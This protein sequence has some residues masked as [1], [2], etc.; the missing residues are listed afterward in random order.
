MTEELKSSKKAPIPASQAKIPS[1]GMPPRNPPQ[2]NP[3]FNNF[4]SKGK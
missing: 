4:G 2:Q 1:V 3:G